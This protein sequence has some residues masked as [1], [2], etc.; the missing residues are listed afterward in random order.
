MGET[1]YKT[2]SGLQ[3]R[4]IGTPKGPALTIIT[5]PDGVVLSASEALG[6]FKPIG[7]FVLRLL[8]P[9]ISKKNR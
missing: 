2:A 4:I 9:T 5:P 1:I 8:K 3:I 7:N 6:L